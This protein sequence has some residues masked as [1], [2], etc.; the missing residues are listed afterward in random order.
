MLGL[1]GRERM[2]GFKLAKCDELREFE[3]CSPGPLVWWRGKQGR[4]DT[5]SRKGSRRGPND[6]GRALEEDLGCKPTAG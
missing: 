5:D 3:R 4:V 1:T 2:L 6:S